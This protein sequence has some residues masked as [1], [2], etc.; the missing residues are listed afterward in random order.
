[1]RWDRLFADLEGEAAAMEREA[2]EADVADRLRAEVSALRLSDRLQPQR[3][4]V[5]TGL[6][7]DG[8]TVQGVV[9]EVG[10]DWVAMDGGHGRSFVVPLSAVVWLGGLSGRATSPPA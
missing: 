4:A 7:K 3:D 2:F 10:E 6:L 8:Q 1:M 9:R 5:L